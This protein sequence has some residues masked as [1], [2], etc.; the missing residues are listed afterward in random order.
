VRSALIL[1]FLRH[2]FEIELLRPFGGAV[3]HLL[4]PCLN[5][6]KLN[7]GSPESQSIVRLLIE[8]DE[9]LYTDAAYLPSDFHVGICR[10]R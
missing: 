4:Y 5:H 10:K 6:E 8:I 3:L 2:R 9:L 1:P 7:D